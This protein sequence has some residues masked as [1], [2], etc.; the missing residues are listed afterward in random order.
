MSVEYIF[1][2][3]IDHSDNTSL[4]L[5]RPKGLFD[6]INKRNP[7]LWDLYKL[8]KLMDWDEQEF[9]FSSCSMD[10]KTC[11]ADVKDIMIKTLAWQWEADSVAAHNL[12]PIV[13]AFVSSSELWAAWSAI[14]V[15]EILHAATYS[16]IVRFSFEHPDEVMSHILA[17]LK[18]LQRLDIIMGVFARTYEVSHRLALGEINRDSDEAY[19]AIFLMVIAMLI[20][21][22]IQFMGSFAITFA[23]ADSGW[24][25]P[26]GQAVQK[27][28]MDELQVHVKTNKAVLNNE[29]KTIRG[30]EA[31]IRNL[32]T[33]KL[34]LKEAIDTEIDFNC[35]YLFSDHK[36]LTGLNSSL[37]RKWILFNANDV[38][39]LLGIA[40]PY[41]IISKNPLGYI[42]GW[43]DI[44]T[45]MVSP[46]EGRGANYLLGGVI[47]TL[48]DKVLDIDF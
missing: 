42:T 10:F 33:I 39:N 4:F 13:A 46:Q 32:K 12:N 31:F 41:E 36:E 48:K 6:T 19:D 30:Q 35:N 22:R 15:N 44:N 5:Q 18:S 38:Y 28:C 34:M 2:A 37:I 29:L 40:N 7:E 17:D 14:G 1:T 20:L 26:I 45:T 27:I 3:N 24:F 47:D 43:I 25:V 8:M 23:I 11:P 21:E 9:D 16:E